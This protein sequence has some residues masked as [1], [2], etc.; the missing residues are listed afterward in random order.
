MSGKTTEGRDPDQPDEELL[1]A[2]EATGIIGAALAPP[3]ADDSLVAVDPGGDTLTQPLTSTSTS[4]SA[5]TSSSASSAVPRDLSQPADLQ[6]RLNVDPAL[7][8]CVYALRPF[9]RGE[10][11]FRERTALE[12]THDADPRGVR[13]VYDRYCR[14][15]PARKRGLHGSFPVLAWANGVDAHEAAAARTLIG[16][17]IL[18]DPRSG[19]Q[20]LVLDIA[21][22]AADHIRMRP[23]S[24]Q[25]LPSLETAAPVASSGASERLQPTTTWARAALADL[26]FRRKVQSRDTSPAPAPLSV[27]GDVPGGG[28]SSGPGSAAAAP[29]F[30][31]VAVAPPPSPDAA[32][33]ETLTWF[34]RYA[35]RLKPN[36]AFG[37]TGGHH[38]AAVYLLTD[39][40]NHRCAG[41]QNCRVAAEIGTI[42]VVAL[43]DIAAG[44]EVT[45]NYSKNVKDFQCKGECCVR[46]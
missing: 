7:G 8:F 5:T 13:N 33:R 1:A 35:F 4:S 24:G 6:V 22:T 32:R 26:F 28:E 19:G 10:R 30:A 44:E 18:R 31:A 39:L 40:I 12:A 29:V 3:T 15:S 20:R 34:S 45:I 46:K 21:L 9:A 14:L 11:L 42:A 38:Q 2:T 43:R 17:R 27:A 36:S 25:Q 37:Q 16:S 23:D 41:F